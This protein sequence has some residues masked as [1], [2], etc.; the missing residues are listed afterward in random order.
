MN[1]DNIMDAWAVFLRGTIKK[2]LNP[3]V[4]QTPAFIDGV[5][6]PEVV[7]CGARRGVSP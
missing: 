6:M 5:T 7:C 1:I 4:T 2:V 3:T